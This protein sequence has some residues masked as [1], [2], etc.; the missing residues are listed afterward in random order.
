MKKNVITEVKVHK[1]NIVQSVDKDQIAVQLKK[2]SEWP[3][4]TFRIVGDY[5]I[6][7][8]L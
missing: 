1:S 3:R 2:Y 7:E 8:K 5:Y 6:L 4:F